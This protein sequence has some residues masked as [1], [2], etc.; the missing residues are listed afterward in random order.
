MTDS[1]S[2]NVQY[3]SISRLLTKKVG[4]LYVGGFDPSFA[5]MKYTK[6]LEKYD[7][8]IIECRF[9]NNTWIFMRE[10]TDKSFPNS[11]KT[12]RCKYISCNF[13]I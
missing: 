6:E 2:Y 8:K 7:G 11:Y 5:R 13:I 12:A 1:F 9:E 10:R 3:L 4:F